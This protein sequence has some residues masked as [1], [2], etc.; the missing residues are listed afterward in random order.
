M[1]R[2]WW[3]TYREW[4][5]S[6]WRE[7]WWSSWWS[8]SGWR[9]VR[10]I[11]LLEWLLRSNFFVGIFFSCSGQHSLIMLAG[12]KRPRKDCGRGSGEERPADSDIQGNFVRFYKIIFWQSAP[13]KTWPEKVDPPKKCCTRCTCTTNTLSTQSAPATFLDMIIDN[14]CTCTRCTCTTSTPSMPS[15]SSSASCSTSLLSFS[16]SSSST[17]WAPLSFSDLLERFLKFSF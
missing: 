3:F 13:W 2:L 4:S 11:T 9:C 15:S 6:Q 5:G 16:L 1:I 10:I 17:G 8:L 7:A 12:A 14:T